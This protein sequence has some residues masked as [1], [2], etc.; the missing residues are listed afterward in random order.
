[1][2]VIS[3]LTNYT[4]YEGIQGRQNPRSYDQKRRRE[5]MLTHAYA[6]LETDIRLHYV[7]EGTGKLLL[8]LHGNPAF[9]YGWKRQLPAFSDRYCVVAPDLPGYNLSSKPEPVERYRMSVLADDI[10]A[11]VEQ[12]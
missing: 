7:T 8:F 4:S 3:I 10:R 9:W 6:D 12:L 1:M 11:F 5:M 2:L